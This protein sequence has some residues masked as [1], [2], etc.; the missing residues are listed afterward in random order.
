MMSNCQ[1]GERAMEMLRREEDKILLRD[2]LDEYSNS[3]ILK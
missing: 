2:T 3:Y 1:G